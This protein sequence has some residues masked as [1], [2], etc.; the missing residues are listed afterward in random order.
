[1]DSASSHE[2]H[3]RSSSYLQF[4]LLIKAISRM[5]FLVPNACELGSRESELHQILAPNHL[6]F[7]FLQDLVD[8]L[9]ADAGL[10]DLGEDVCEHQRLHAGTI[11]YHGI[12]LLAA[13]RP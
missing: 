9:F 6:A 7:E 1:M 12:I 3:L 4:A 5:P 8:D 11:R 10:V 2:Q 13:D